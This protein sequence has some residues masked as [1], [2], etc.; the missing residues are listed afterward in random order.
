MGLT[1]LMTSQ[2]YFLC[3]IPETAVNIWGIVEEQDGTVV[4]FPPTL[5]VTRR[6]VFHVLDE[7]SEVRKFGEERASS[8]DRAMRGAA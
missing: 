8:R 6:N 5:V 1:L 3:S 4:L 7:T 2:P